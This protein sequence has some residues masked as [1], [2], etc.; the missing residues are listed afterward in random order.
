MSTRSKIHKQ[1]PQL[2]RLGAPAAGTISALALGRAAG[3]TIF[4]GSPVG[5]YRARAEDGQAVSNWERLSTAPMGILAL[6]V[7]PNFAADPTVLA[8]TNTGIYLSRDGG[9]TWKSTTMP[10]A[11][12]RVPDICFSSHYPTD[13]MVLA[14]T[15]ED[16]VVISK[17]RGE[18]WYSRS[19]GLLDTAIFA[20]AFSPDFNSDDTLYAGTDTALYFSYNQ[21]LAWKDLHFPEASAPILSLAVAPGVSSP[22][23]YVGTEANGLYRSAGQGE[24]WEKLP[25][26]AACINAL[27]WIEGAAE[28]S[29]ATEAGVYQSVDHGKTWSLKL[30]RPNIISLATSAGLSV[31]GSIEQG[32]WLAEGQ[33]EW[34]PVASLTSRSFVGLALSP[35]FKADH[36]A[37]LYGPQERIWHTTDGGHTWQPLQADLPK[38]EFRALTIAPDFADSHGLAVAADAGILISDDAGQTWKR[39][40]K[41]QADW[42]AYSPNGKVL[43]ASLVNLGIGVSEV[44]GKTWH[45][46]PGQWDVGGRILALAVTNSNYFHVAL[47]EGVGATVSLWHG[48]P[49]EYE[50]VLT[51]PIGPNPLVSLFV[52]ADPN[53]NQA[54]YAGFGHQ[55]WKFSAR[56]GRP[57]APATVFTP[58]EPGEIILQLIGL[59]NQVGQLL[60]VGTGRRL[61]TMTNGQDWEEAYDFGRERA[62]SVALSPD[63]PQ[64]KTVYAL[65]VGGSVCQLVLS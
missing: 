43:A 9:E 20:V 25:L 49:G 44:Q 46:V 61:F 41:E 22:M 40:L 26:P 28:L 15:L 53:P 33:G 60:I 65:L 54:W 32:I 48:K 56:K 2:I 58:A 11:G 30:N 14:G 36:T 1:A 13:G 52:P 59:Q 50:K 21:G 3:L 5:L 55:V 10:M 31:A 62:I 64:D 51:E 38:F 8:G 29:A 23:V 37:Y 4:A 6:A 18:T 16:G 63:Y 27:E 17:D 35:A 12:S 42:V 24:A 47:L 7:A 57:G 45:H 34:L 19:F 39:S